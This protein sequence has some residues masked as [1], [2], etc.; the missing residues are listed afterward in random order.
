MS[1]DSVP[2]IMIQLRFYKVRFYKQKTSYSI[3]IDASGRYGTKKKISL[4]PRDISPL[5]L[6]DSFSPHVGGNNCMFSSQHI[7]KA[8]VLLGLLR[9]LFSHKIQLLHTEGVIKFEYID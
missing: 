2:C 1:S 3:Y 6:C 9:S 4:S 8:D 5:L 7:F